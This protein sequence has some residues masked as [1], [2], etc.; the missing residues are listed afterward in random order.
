[1]SESSDSKNSFESSHEMSASVGGKA[2]SEERCS[3][4]AP[5]DMKPRPFVDSLMTQ[6]K[7]LLWK[8]LTEIKK[9]PMEIAKIFVPPIFMFLLIISMYAVFF[10]GSSG[11]D[12][13]VEV[14]LLPFAFWIFAQKIVV[15]IMFEKHYRLYEAMKMMGLKETS[16]WISYYLFDAVFIGFLVSFLCM[17]C[18]T[19]GLFNHGNLGGILGFLMCFFFSIT[20][21][22]YFLTTFFDTP[23]SSGQ[24]TIG[25]LLG[26]Y[27][28][29]MALSVESA[30]EGL[31]GMYCLFPP[32]A[33]QLGCA[34]FQDSY[35]G[36]DTSNICGI[37][38]RISN[39]CFYHLNVIDIVLI[40]ML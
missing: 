2:V 12:G 37:M 32:L 9:Q 13:S 14:F 36:I 22:S 19:Y 7:I 4:S 18:S 39:C 30:S 34:S 24:I 3:I 11:S 8:R 26:F 40:Y 33:F 15:Y 6:I 23:Q 29:Y 25:I 16:Y 38:V 5:S 20:P 1:M 31:Q 21:F 17:I 35:S 28:L 10:G 27:V